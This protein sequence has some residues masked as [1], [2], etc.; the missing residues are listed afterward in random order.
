MAVNIMGRIVRDKNGRLRVRGYD[1][2]VS[3]LEDV[4]NDAAFPLS[5]QEAQALMY[6]AERDDLPD[7]D[8]DGDEP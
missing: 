3:A 7:Y 2:N 1:A 8:P 6:Q 5:D 4:L